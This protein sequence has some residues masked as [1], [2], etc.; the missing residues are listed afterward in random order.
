MV[1]REDNPCPCCD[2]KLSMKNGGLDGTTERATIRS[3]SHKWGD[4]RECQSDGN[5]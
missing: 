3:H 2:L 5:W 4:S 1:K